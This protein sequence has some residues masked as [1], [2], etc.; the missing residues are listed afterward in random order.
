MTTTAPTT[1]DDRDV[2]FMQ[3][4][5]DEAR[6]AALHDDVPV[7]CV[8]VDDGEIIGIGENRRE[9]DQDPTAHAEII[10]LRDAAT[11]RDGW[12]MDGVT[13]Y[14]TLEPCVMC[15]GALLNARVA[16]VVIGT[17]DE[18]AGAV[19]SRYNILSDP[20]LLHEARVTYDVLREESQFLLREFFASRRP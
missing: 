2:Q 19:G 11:R 1:N 4:A 5:L 12:R 16:H 8:L 3:R 9:V 13:A 10:A 18:K 20:R 17:M 15:A 14:V 6:L 7:G